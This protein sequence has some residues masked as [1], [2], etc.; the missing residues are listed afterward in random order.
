MVFYRNA[1]LRKLHVLFTVVVVLA[2]CAHH[3]P[4]R[5]FRRCV[6]PFRLPNI[7][8]NNKLQ[9]NESDMLGN[10]FDIRSCFEGA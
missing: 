6:A 4:E 7:P 2:S 5:V 1:M 3:A 9:R 8:P 10:A